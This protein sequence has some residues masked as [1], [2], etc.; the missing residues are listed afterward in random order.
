MEIIIKKNK[1]GFSLMKLFELLFFIT[2]LFLISTFVFVVNFLHFDILL[3][4]W[5]VFFSI[6]LYLCWLLFLCFFVFFIINS[7]F[8]Q[9]RGFEVVEIDTE[10][11]LIKRR[12][13]LVKDVV[14]IPLNEIISIDQQKYIPVTFKNRF[15]GNPFSFSRTIGEIGGHIKITYQKKKK[16]TIEFGFGLSKEEAFHFIEQMKEILEQQENKMKTLVNEL[17]MGEKS[18]INSD[19][20]RE[21]TLTDFHEKH[22]QI[23]YLTKE[24]AIKK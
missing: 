10:S 20:G 11:L 17:K 8:W 9:F 12:G 23:K 21:D 1:N 13:Q 4:D 24:K 16:K 3:F 18:K 5:K 6:L 7:I 14:T 19:F 22:I 15:S 2:S